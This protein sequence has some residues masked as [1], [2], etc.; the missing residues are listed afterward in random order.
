MQ[1]NPQLPRGVKFDARVF[2]VVESIEGAA[3]RCQE[4][5]LRIGRDELR[6][7]QQVTDLNLRTF[8]VWQTGHRISHWNKK[9]KHT[10]ELA[11]V[12]TCY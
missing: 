9:R 6:L 8:T 1:V 12:A 5:G 10:F 11:F 7:L 4:V 2:L 3:H